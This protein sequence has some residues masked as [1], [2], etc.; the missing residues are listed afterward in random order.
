FVQCLEQKELFDHKEHRIVKA[1]EQESPVCAVPDARCSPDDC[2][3]EKLPCF[4]A[5]VPAKR[6][7]HI[8]AEPGT[9][10]HMPPA[11][12]LRYALGDIRVV[13]VLFE[14]KSY[15]APKSDSHIGIT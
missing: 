13:E 2:D 3:I 4:A 1:P 11:P 7:I 10:R 8:V 12:E 6:D 9:E 14:L 5:A 15:H